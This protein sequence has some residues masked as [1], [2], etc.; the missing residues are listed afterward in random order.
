MTKISCLITHSIGEIDILLPVIY[1]L[2]TKYNIKIKIIFTVKKIHEDYKEN[3]FFQHALNSNSIDT[4]FIQSCNKFDYPINQ[5][6]FLSKIILKLRKVIFFF[7]ILI[8]IF[9]S[10]FLLH[11]ITNQIDSTFILYLLKKFFKKNILVYNHALGS[12]NKNTNV[13]KVNY[14]KNS[15][16]LSFHN[17]ENEYI[18]NKGFKGH[19]YI[20]NPKLD[21]LWIQ[22]VKEYKIS[23]QSSFKKNILVLMQNSSN[24]IDEEFYIDFCK[25][26]IKLLNKYF[27]ESIIL[28]KNHPRQ[29]NTILKKNINFNKKIQLYENDIISACSKSI[30]IVSLHT[31]AVIDAHILGKKV[32]EICL[33]KH[34]W[35]VQN[36]ERP[37]YNQFTDVSTNNLTDFEFNLRRIKAKSLDSQIKTN[38]INL[39]LNFINEQF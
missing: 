24:F 30:F 37:M 6:N 23:D 34:N 35:K 32:I 12:M 17:D 19:F 1:K 2:K 27:P 29:N 7:R 13:E 31:S 18:K 39:N 5:R 21:P 26:I 9:D 20:G 3:Y 11:E 16:Y 25:Q 33:P 14:Y 15:F 38:K 10:K 4:F 8:K 36:I 22:Y 28:L